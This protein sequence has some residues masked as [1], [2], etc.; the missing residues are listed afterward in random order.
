MKKLLYLALVCF[1]IFSYTQEFYYY[2]NKH[3]ELKL[4]TRILYVLSNASTKD[5][6]NEELKEYGTITYVTPDVYPKRLVKNFSNAPNWMIQEGNSYAQL[7]LHDS[8]R[9]E[10]HVH[11]LM[12]EIK[13]KPHMLHV[14]NYYSYQNTDPFAITYAV[15]VQL[16]RIEDIQV[17]KQEALKR[18]YFVLGQNPF[19]PEWVML[20]AD[21]NATSMPLAISRELH[22]LNLFESVEPDMRGVMKSTCVNDTYFSSKWGLSNT[23]Q[24]SGTPGIDIRACNAWGITTGSPNVDVAVIDHGFENNHPDLMGNLEN[25]GYDAQVGTSPS[26]M[27]GNHGTPCAGII[28]A[29]GSNN[30]GVIGV[31]PSC[32]LMSISEQVTTS[33]AAEAADGFNWA[34][35][36]G[37]EVISNSWFVNPPS[38][39]LEASI[40]LAFTLGRSNL[41]C[42]VVF[43]TGNNNG[44]ILYP[45]NFDPNIITVGA[46]SPCGE[47]KNPSSCDGET[48]GSN[49]GNELDVVAPGVLIS[50]TDR[51]GNNGYNTNTTMNEFTNRDYTAWFNGTSSACPH[52]AGVAALIL[53]VNPCLN[54]GQ[55]QQII[56]RT[57]QKVGGYNYN[58]ST[59]DG[60]WNNEMG[61]GLV[62]AEAAVIMAQSKYLQNLYL[63][64]NVTYQSPRIMAGYS[65]N[66]FAPYG[67]VTT[68]SS[69]S[70]S[71]LAN[72]SIE[73]REGCDL[74]GTVNIQITNIANCFSW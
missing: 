2:K 11:Q 13:K 70:V 66:A 62:N 29:T 23:G 73:L 36:N 41:G 50:S 65:V 64:G 44:A 17:L 63:N 14:S 5:L 4:N 6:L 43:A 37:A 22:A 51:Q 46:V 16:K 39:L 49:Y 21:T 38:V 55:V 47:R 56:R 26:G 18:N 52:V 12:Q 61:Y 24:Y 1:P 42:V 57:S 28:A 69:A 25:N 59:S 8:N 67:N 68:T 74:Q 71:M 60:G 19:M 9:T 31:A 33:S 27:Y 7:I 53:S 15:W 3:A 30:A 32:N 20:G 10:Q 58:T 54:Q 34:R 40:I 72:Q 45:A 35:L 48:W